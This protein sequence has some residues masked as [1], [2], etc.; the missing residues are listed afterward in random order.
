[1]NFWCYNWARLD[2][3]ASH[4]LF[5]GTIPLSVSLNKLLLIEYHEISVLCEP[6]SGYRQTGLQVL[7]PMGL[8]PPKGTGPE[9]FYLRL[10]LVVISFAILSLVDS[11]TSSAPPPPTPS[12]F[13]PINTHPFYNLVINTVPKYLAAYEV[14]GRV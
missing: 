14:G 11:C 5:K 2:F 4:I 12:F 7:L 10:L 9:L 1:M 8:L 13:F 6:S 3:S